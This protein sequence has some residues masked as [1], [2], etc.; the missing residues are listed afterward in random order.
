MKT[1]KIISCWAKAVFLARKNKSEKEKEEIMARLK[2]ILKKTKKEHLLKKIQE[3]MER[4]FGRENRAELIL[5]R[6]PESAFLARLKKKLD[7]VLAQKEIKVKV[8]KGI[9]AGFRI[10]TGNILIKSSIKDFLASLQE[11]LK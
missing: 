2:K 7:Y 3:R 11:D 1:E 10:K 8:D 6:T 5:A 4:V 9:I